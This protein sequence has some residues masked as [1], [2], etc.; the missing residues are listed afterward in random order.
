MTIFFMWAFTLLVSRVF[1][2]HEAWNHELDKREKEKYLL[3]KCEDPEF[4]HNIRFHTDICTEVAANAR[5]SILLKALNTVAV[6]T[7]ICGRHPCSEVLSGIVS[8]IGWQ[9]SALLTA[10]ADTRTA[11][12]Y[13]TPVMCICTN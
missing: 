7:H 5:S 3:A 8:R 12:T 11:L 13:N 9:V 4:F 6:N 10:H 2:F 1:I